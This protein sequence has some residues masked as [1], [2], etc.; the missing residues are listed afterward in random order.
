M[1][2]HRSPIDHIRNAF[3]PLLAVLGLL[4]LF[5]VP[6]TAAP[7][8]QTLTSDSSY[9]L[10]ITAQVPA[11]G[12][13]VGGLFTITG[14][15]QW[16]TA[17]A[18][19][20]TAAENATI[21]VG[22]GM[23]DP[24][25]S[26]NVGYTVFKGV[27]SASEPGQWTMAINTTQYNDGTYQFKMTGTSDHY[28]CGSLAF[29]LAL[30]NGHWAQIVSASITADKTNL[31]Q[32]QYSNVTT[33]AQ[34]N[35]GFQPDQALVYFGLVNGTGIAAPATMT[36]VGP[37]GSP[38]TYTLQLQN[39]SAFP[40]RDLQGVQ[41]VP[42]RIMLLKGGQLWAD[43]KVTAPLH[44]SITP[45]PG[46][47]PLMIPPPGVNPKNPPITWI[48]PAAAAGTGT[49]LAGVGGVWAFRRSKRSKP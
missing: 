23:E 15:I 29:T 18:S 32:G 11:P 6:A 22:L 19:K 42:V 49:A 34:V 16:N 46:G 17:W 2:N 48:G 38:P 14:Q 1:T 33:I 7:T 40:T 47:K 30:N 27:G 9:P 31:V 13:V 5:V 8:T 3:P 39:T 12:V 21:R 37:Q 36:V 43:A 44:L 24:A 25:S 28:G 20:A 10:I 26:K 4:V 45:G 41:D 35:T